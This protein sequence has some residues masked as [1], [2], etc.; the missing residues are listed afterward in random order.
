MLVLKP[1]DVGKS[2]HELSFT[3]APIWVQIH[4]LSLGRMTRTTAMDATSK[5][6]EVLDIDF[7]SQLHVWGAEF[8]WCQVMLNLLNPLILSYYFEHGVDDKL[9]IQFKYEKN[10]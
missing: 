4:G 3:V 9:W 10:C 7:H 8:L 2:L 6:G 5:A 1:L